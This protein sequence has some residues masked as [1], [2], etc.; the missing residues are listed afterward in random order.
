MARDIVLKVRLILYNKGR[1]LLLKQRKHTGG[2][3]TLVGG[4]IESE[5]FAIESL[6]RES[7]EEAGINLKRKDLELAHVL[8][9]K[10]KNGERVTLYFK[11]KKWEGKPRALEP[12]KFKEAVW[13]HLNDLP[14]NLT[15]TVRHVLKMYR[16]GILYSEYKN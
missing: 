5:E 7:L 9:K 4:T 11:A 16:A 3:H 6:I 10:T 14:E 1:I 2:N 8:H 12:D 15:G 13:Y